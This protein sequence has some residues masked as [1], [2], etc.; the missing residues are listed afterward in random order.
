MK[1]LQKLFLLSV[2]GLG[3]LV[4]EMQAKQAEIDISAQN[5]SAQEAAIK[6]Q[7]DDLIL[8]KAEK[9]Q[10]ATA[11]G[12]D[13]DAIRQILETLKVELMDIIEKSPNPSYYSKLQTALQQLQPTAIYT[14]IAP[15]KVIL[16]HASDQTRSQI[17]SKLPVHLAALL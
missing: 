7:I 5:I 8:N 6:K 16:S 15:F 17:K 10:Q 14:L 3:V 1:A 9:L 13:L 11:T 4:H 12:L 2:L